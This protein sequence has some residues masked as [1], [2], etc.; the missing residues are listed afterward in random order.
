MTR[1][2]SLDGVRGL[3][4]FAV[5]IHHV[6]QVI[7]RYN[8]ATNHDW[9]QSIAYWPLRLLWG[10]DEAVIAF[11]VMSGFVLALPFLRPER[12]SWIRFA[13]RRI[14]RL[15]PPYL[16]ALVVASVSAGFFAPSRS[17]QLVRVFGHQWPADLGM[18][19]FVNSALMANEVQLA[20]GV[21]WSIVQEM[22]ISLVFPILFLVT[23]RIGI[24][25]AL[26]LSFFLSLGLA[27]G[28]YEWRFFEQLGPTA[29]SYLRTP[30]YF[31]FFVLGIAMAMFR[32]VLQERLA[33]AWKDLRMAL[34]ILGL[35]GLG[36]YF[37][38]PYGWGALGV[39]VG[40][41][42]LLAVV[43]ST[44]A[45]N[46]F[47]EARV[48]Q[49][50]GKISYS[51]Y[52]IHSPVLLSMLCL[53]DGVVPIGATLLAA[54]PASILAAWAFWFL[55]ERPSITWSRRVALAPAEAG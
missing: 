20:N 45:G 9:D 52:L 47:L 33:G 54:V 8:D 53:L 24:V 32:E 21:L 43:I 6:M 23:Y 38:L 40:F 11:F 46:R 5:V 10:G 55:V 15:Y 12:P 19:H 7:H 29:I 37:H 16:L 28:M 39:A 49:Y 2:E 1:I 13:L 14:I 3:A 22:R 31:F 26:T 18:A 4:A 41:S 36:L 44:D 34:A 17:A 30:L 48:P 25:W 35:G 51:L 50:L 42:V 27:F